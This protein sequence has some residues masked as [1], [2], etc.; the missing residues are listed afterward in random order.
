[1]LHQAFPQ[2][3]SFPFRLSTMNSGYLMQLHNKCIPHSESLRFEIHVRQ[4]FLS[5][6]RASIGLSLQF[7]TQGQEKRQ[8]LWRL[9]RTKPGSVEYPFPGS[10][11]LTTRNSCGSKPM[12]PF[13]L[14]GAPP[15]Y[16]IL[17]GIGMF[18]GGTIWIWT[19]GPNLPAIP[20]QMNPV[21]DLCFPELF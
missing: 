3:V 11:P 9:G 21:R 2:H 6:N 10:C 16:S 12:V 7:I 17:A 15:I 4:K 1:M 8:A 19:H 5:L 13:W 20:I 14:V 18:T